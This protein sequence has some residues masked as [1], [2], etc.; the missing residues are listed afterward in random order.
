[1]KTGFVHIHG[2]FGFDIDRRLLTAVSG[3]ANGGNVA[4]FGL[5]IVTPAIH[6]S[7]SEQESENRAIENM[8]NNLISIS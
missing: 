7:V 2:Q 3:A 5:I 8:Y 4:P 1:M 6:T